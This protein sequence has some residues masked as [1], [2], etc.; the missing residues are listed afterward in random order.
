MMPLD[1]GLGDPIL[2]LEGAIEMRS[3][4]VL[5]FCR[6]AVLCLGAGVVV[7][8]GCSDNPASPPT[9]PNGPEIIPPL[10]GF[11]AAEFRVRLG[12]PTRI[13]PLPPDGIWDPRSEPISPE[14]AGLRVETRDLAWTD[15]P[16]RGVASLSGLWR[17]TNCDG[18]VRYFIQCRIDS[19]SSGITASLEG[20]FVALLPDS[21]TS[22]HPWTFEA[23]GDEDF[24]F[25]FAASWSPTVVAYH[26]SADSVWGKPQIFL[27]EPTGSRTAPLTSHNSE[28][29]WPQVSPDGT[30]ICFVSTRAS[31]LGRT[32][33]WSM[34]L[35][36]TGLFR[37]VFNFNA[38]DM[39]CWSPDGAQIAYQQLIEDIWQI[40]LI[41]AD[42]TNPVN[43]SNSDI[44]E[45]HPAFSADGTKI[46]FLTNRQGPGVYIMNR[47]GSVKRKWVDYPAYDAVWSPD[48]SWLAYRAGLE[49]IYCYQV[50][51]TQLRNL[52]LESDGCCHGHPAWSPDGWRL[53]FEL[54]LG[55][56]TQEVYLINRDGTGM[57]RLTYS[58]AVTAHNPSWG[59]LP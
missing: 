5:F 54:Q 36:G 48:G 41:N 25:N 46:I 7:V 27:T 23:P 56:G 43:L 19:L 34:K 22:W 52:T 21:S 57:S 37:V 18:R 6:L 28:N 55:D 9:P 4:N 47:D 16:A 49:D 35:D 8:T 12:P 30:R 39:P 59:P 3:I 17:L 20:E 29:T 10:P 44:G 51:G 13:S 40:F 2:I 31:F 1:A 15:Q 45:F 53:L 14:T 32:Q 38:N 42:G 58:G 33:I 24:T 26:V 11:E 50:D